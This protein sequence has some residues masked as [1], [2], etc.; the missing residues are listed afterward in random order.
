MPRV[1]PSEPDPVW[2]AVGSPD[3]CGRSYFDSPAVFLRLLD[4]QK[5]G[6]CSVRVADMI[7]TSRRYIKGTN[8]LET[9]FTASSGSLTVTDFMPMRANSEAGQQAGRVFRLL[10][11]TSGSVDLRVDIKPTFAFASEQSR[12]DTQA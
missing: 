10:R 2:L 12:L 1:A 3:R 6:Y 4:R 11:C 8:I 5:G 9:T 7:S